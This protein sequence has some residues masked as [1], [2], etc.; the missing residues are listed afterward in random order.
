MVERFTVNRNRLFL[1]EPILQTQPQVNGNNSWFHKKDS[2]RAERII[3]EQ[4]FL[5]KIAINVD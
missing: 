1:I 5:K 4:V 2:F 3:S